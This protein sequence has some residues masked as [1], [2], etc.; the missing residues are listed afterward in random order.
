MQILLR[1]IDLHDDG[2]RMRTGDLNIHVMANLSDLSVFF[3][4][5][6]LIDLQ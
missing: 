4:R 3:Y 1:N 6:H 5:E 2:R